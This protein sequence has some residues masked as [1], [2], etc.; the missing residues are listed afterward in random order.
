MPSDAKQNLLT[1]GTRLFA[2]HGFAG[3]SVRD[4]C[5]EAGVGRN[6]IHHYFGNKDGLLQ[7]ILD[8]FSNDA[9]AAAIRLIGKPATSQ[10]EYR[11]KLE[12]FISEVFE[13]LVSNAQILRIA[14]REAGT[15][16]PLTDLRDR[17]IAYM[18]AAQ[19]AGYIAPEQDV[20]MVPG[21]ILDR[22]GGQ[23]LYALRLE[24][25]SADNVLVNAQYREEWL[26]A[27]SQLLLYGL[28]AR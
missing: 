13:V 15:Y 16:L 10:D 22:L 19:E 25:T 11:L 8:A 26:A 1:A 7:A 20:A 5:A 18:Q 6:M 21:F 2:E 23:I 24:G 28:V 3:A 12:L 4:I 17:L 27:N 9:F 14:S